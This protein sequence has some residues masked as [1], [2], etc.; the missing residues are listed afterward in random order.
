MSGTVTAVTW[1]IRKSCEGTWTRAESKL[2]AHRSHRSSATSHDTLKS[3]SRILPFSPICTWNGSRQVDNDTN[4]ERKI[5]TFLLYVVTVCMAC[6][7]GAMHSP[8][9]NPNQ[10]GAIKANPESIRGN[11][12]KCKSMKSNEDKPRSIRSNRD[13]QTQIN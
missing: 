1:I 7:A 13:K 4:V 2:E 10:Y 12:N 3:S 5:A 11:Q 9:P 6:R 8:Q